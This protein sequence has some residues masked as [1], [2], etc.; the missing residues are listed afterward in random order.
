M[1]ENPQHLPSRHAPPNTPRPRYAYGVVL[2]LLSAGLLWW[3]TGAYAATGA[4]QNPEVLP[5]AGPLIQHIREQGHITV[6]VRAYRRPSPDPEARP[7]PDEY[8]LALAR[9]LAHR[10]QVELR[11]VPQAPDSDGLIA[12]DADSVDL[13][14]GLAGDDGTG[15]M[16]VRSA[17]SSALPRGDVVVLARPAQQSLS[18]KLALAGRTV[19]A[20]Q[21]SPYALP[22][23]QAYDV[24]IKWLP[25]TIAALSAFSAFECD[26]LLA[27]ADLL[28]RLQS[29]PDW[30]YYRRLTTAL[31][32]A[33]ADQ[34]TLHSGD[35]RDAQ[36][37]QTLLAEWSASDD[38]QAHRQQRLS[39][40]AFEATQLQPG[41]YCH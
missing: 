20:A 33:F 14:L 8:D 15:S 17:A 39:L 40:Q 12:L 36:A 4:R 23:T 9:A 32:P 11:T 5:E 24:Q 25:S 16:V 10:L 19:C 29:A 2:S 30:A 1:A 22:A 41:S 34:A 35:A 27:D 13:L 28:D 6:G 26:G 21:G 18:P 38:G 7:E 3:L 31:R 37:V